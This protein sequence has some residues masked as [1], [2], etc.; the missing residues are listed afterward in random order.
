VLSGAKECFV[1]GTAAG[2]TPIASLSYKGKK[3]VFGG[4]RP[5]ELTAYIRDTLKGIQ[6][7][8][9]PDTKGWLVKVI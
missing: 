5:G 6:Y 4:G 8:L 2:A 1:S 9:L 3:T 7:G